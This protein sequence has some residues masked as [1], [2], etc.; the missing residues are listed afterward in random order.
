M[1]VWGTRVYTTRVCYYHLLIL[2]SGLKKV[3]WHILQTEFNACVSTF[4][5]TIR[6]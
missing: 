4:R 6:V 3:H 1:E 2:R 5:T